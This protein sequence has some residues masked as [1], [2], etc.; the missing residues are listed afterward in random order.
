MIKRRPAEL[1]RP[2]LCPPPVGI[3]PGEIMVKRAIAK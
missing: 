3:P 1:G 2:E